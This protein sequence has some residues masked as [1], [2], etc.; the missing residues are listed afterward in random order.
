MNEEKSI[1]SS[2][3]FWLGLIT[4][5]IGLCSFLIGEEFI[6]QWPYAVSA[7]LM[8]KGILDVLIRAITSQPVRLSLK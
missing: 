8:I 6:Q 4:F 7:I 3:T 2:K 5:L 1:F